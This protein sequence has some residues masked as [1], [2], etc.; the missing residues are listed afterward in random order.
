MSKGEVYEKK[1]NHHFS[2]EV[3]DVQS[4]LSAVQEELADKNKTIESL[5]NENKEL[6]DKKAA[7]ESLEAEYK[8]QESEKADLEEAVASIQAEYEGYQEEMEPFEAMNAAQ[9]EASKAEAEKIKASIEAEEKASQEAAEASI[10]V[11]RAAAEAERLASEAAEEAERLAKEKAGYNTGI[12]FDQLARTPDEYELEKVKFT[13]TVIQVMEGDDVIQ[14]RFAVNDD[15]DQ[16]LFCEYDPSIVTQRVLE[17]DTITFYGISFG[18]YTY[19]STMGASITIP[20]VV[21]DKIEFS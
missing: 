9:A 8:S 21:I 15:Y 3:G 13:G 12:T 5:V 19:E 18:L 2:A 20:A 16:I 6:A 11:S 7:L 10:A 4:S 1:T 14:I 17:D